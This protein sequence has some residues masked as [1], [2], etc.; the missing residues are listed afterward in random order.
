[1]AKILVKDFPDTY[2]DELYADIDYLNWFID[3]YC[4]T[5]EE[6]QKLID[7]AHTFRSEEFD[8]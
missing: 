8:D 5:R 7:L 4:L 1:M 3:Y 6:L 2:Y